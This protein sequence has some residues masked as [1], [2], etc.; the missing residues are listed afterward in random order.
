MTPGSNVICPLPQNSC[1]N[2]H[3]LLKIKQLVVWFCHTVR[4]RRSMHYFLFV[5]EALSFV[6]T[7]Q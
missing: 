1:K 7:S 2:Y 5:R 3:L 4:V 6:A